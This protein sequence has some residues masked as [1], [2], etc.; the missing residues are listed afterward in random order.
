ML[1]KPIVLIE[2]RKIPPAYSGL[3]QGTRRKRW[4]HGPV[5]MRL[6][7]GLILPEDKGRY[8]RTQQKRAHTQILIGI[9]RSESS[10]SAFPLSKASQSVL[11]PYEIRP[12]VPKV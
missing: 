6:R 2:E 9:V 10:A 3:G 1:G 7:L 8:E 12:T 5:I 4:I 11:G